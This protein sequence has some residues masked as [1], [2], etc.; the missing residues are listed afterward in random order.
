[1]KNGH[2][3]ILTLFLGTMTLYTTKFLNSITA[4]GL[5]AHELKLKVGASVM[6]LRNRNPPKLR[7][8]RRFIV[9]KLQ[10][11]VFEAEILTG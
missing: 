9:R 8:G 4:T 5:P 1:M 6:L 10:L 3:S 7:N 11:C 2:I